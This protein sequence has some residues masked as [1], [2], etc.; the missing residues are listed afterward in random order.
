MK[1]ASWRLG[2]L[3][4]LVLAP[5]LCFADQNHLS[6]VRQ[7]AG[8]GPHPY[9]SPADRKAA[10]F[11]RDRFV[12]CGVTDVRQQ[13]FQ[14]GQ[15]VIATIPGKD[16]SRQIYLAA[17]FDSVRSG[18]GAY[19]D[20]S[21]ISV[22]LGVAA[23]F[24]TKVPPY[25]LVLCAFDG[26]EMGLYGSA[27]YVRRMS[28]QERERALFMLD[29]EMMG[30]KPGLPALETLKYDV[31]RGDPEL[32]RHVGG[33][34]SPLPVVSAVKSASRATGI[35]VAVGDPYLS[36]LYQVC[37]RVVRVAFGG[38]EMPFLLG[39]IPAVQF[40][41]SSF[42]EFDPHYHLATDLPQYV[43]E[44][45]LR[46]MERL[47]IRVVSDAKAGDYHRRRAI[48]SHGQQEYLVVGPLVLRYYLLLALFAAAM[49]LIIYQFFR[50]PQLRFWPSLVMILEAGFSALLFSRFPVFTFFMVGIPAWICVVFDFSGIRSRFR[51]IPILLAPA[52]V[53]VFVAIATYRQFLYGTYLTVPDILLLLFVLSA[54]VVRTA[55]RRRE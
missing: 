39:N 26:E 17:H 49:C 35:P 50:Q 48:Y 20:A 37:I 3:F 40:T 47:V 33:I 23:H 52:I 54:L 43:D 45:R 44:A 19:D 42:S 38:D 4:L 27:H 1:P 9:G 12:A 55:K 22:L 34:L 30:W 53:F 46:E 14:K 16:R 2:G 41:D 25:T 18:P 8:L 6:I 32:S 51:L 31:G 15:N 29:L 24:S 11:V 36:V 21:G 13:P 7:L 28:K 5:L 10:R